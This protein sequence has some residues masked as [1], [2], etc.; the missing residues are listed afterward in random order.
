MV[1]KTAGVSSKHWKIL[2]LIALLLTSDLCPLTC[3]CSAQAPSWWT[4]RGVVGTNAVNDYAPAIQGQLKWLA[5][6]ACAELRTNLLGGAGSGVENLVAG[7]SLGNNYFPVNLGQLKYVAT[8]FYER[9]MEEGY[10]NSYPWTVGTTD[11]ADYAPATLG[12]VKNVFSFDLSDSDSDDLPDW[13]EVKWFGGAGTQ[14]GVDDADGD[15]YLNIYEYQHSSDPTAATNFP[16]PTIVVTNGST[17]TIQAAIDASS[18]DYDIVLVSTGLFTGAGNRDLSFGG[19]KITL[20]SH[21]GATSTVI[22]CEGQGRGLSFHCGESNESVLCGVTIRNGTNAVGGGAILCSNSSPTLLSCIIL[23]NAAS[24]YGGGIYCVDSASPQIRHCSVSCNKSRRMNLIQL[25]DCYGGGICCFD[26]S[27]PTIT[28][29]VISNNKAKFGGGV[30]SDTSDPVILDTIV[31]NND[32]QVSEGGGILIVG[33]TSDLVISN[34]LIMANSA[35]EGGGLYAAAG[36]ASVSWCVILQN[37]AEFTGGGIHCSDATAFSNC[38]VSGN[39]GASWQSVSGGGIYVDGTSRFVNCA[40]TNNLLTNGSGGGVCCGL[41]GSPVFTSCRMS[42][43]SVAG[44]GGGVS[45]VSTGEFWNCVIDHNTATG[46]GGGVSCSYAAPTFVGCTISANSAAFGAGF[47]CRASASPR[48]LN[49]ELIANIASSRGG[50]LGVECTAS[51]GPPEDGWP[52]DS[53]PYL[54]GCTVRA[55]TA[56]GDGAATAFVTNE[57]VS[58]NA[59]PIMENCLLLGNHSVSNGGGVCV[60]GASISLSF[61]SCTVVSNTADKFGGGLYVKNSTNTSVKDTILFFNTTSQIVSSASSPGVSYSCV[62]GGYAGTAIITN[63][64]LLRRD[65]SHLGST[66]SLCFNAGSSN[67][68]STDLDGDSRPSMGAVDIGCDELADVDLDGMPDYWELQYFGGAT[69]ASPG[70]DPDVDELLNLVEYEYDRDPFVAD[71]DDADNDDLSDAL[72]II[73]GADP[74]NPDTDADGMTDGWEYQNGLILTNDDSTADKDADGLS[75]IGE[76]NVG[77]S[78]TNTDSD[79]DGL[80]DGEEVFGARTGYPS[81]PLLSDS[82]DDG[83]PDGQDYFPNSPKGDQD[84]DGIPDA[85]DNDTDN[86]GLTNGL[87]NVDSCPY[88]FRPDSDGDGVVDGT[89]SSP[90]T[91]SIWA[92]PADTNAP[93]ITIVLPKEGAQL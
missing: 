71:L 6:N 86:D 28:S 13:W 60:D 26:N 88:R 90:C 5:T 45:I 22:D 34:C 36:A 35:G 49:C 30:C 51:S 31:C 61:S 67:A 18:N 16:A 32:Y 41:G 74:N 66:N 85:L 14:S 42:G 21:A 46:N 73:H 89:D 91:N 7:F 17:N 81:S 15:G 9:L 48:M 79:A 29:C 39:F 33:G 25:L 4:N 76:W 54:N 47:E 59:T 55:N 8:P 10:T 65:G 92:S 38:L 23:S 24:I 40:I 80:S 44:S 19:K 82:D 62:Q 64:P 87:E 52:R 57:V 37:S 1:G 72:E 3:D 12:Q 83:I 58:G 84:G 68:P 63:N 50:G 20:I 78:A 75:N 11:D 2:G 53:S 77:A 27:R 93:I 69:N 56:G 43:N 70:S